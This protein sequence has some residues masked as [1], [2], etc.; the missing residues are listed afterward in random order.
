MPRDALRFDGEVFS[1]E[2][3]PLGEA[4]FWGSA[5]RDGDAAPWRGWIRLADLNRAELP[6]GRYRVRAFEGWEGE[7]EPVTPRPDRVFEIELLPIRGVG[8]APWPDAAERPPRNRPVWNDTPPRT[9]DDRTRFPP[10]L[11]PL[12]TTPEEGLLP[13]GLDWSPVPE[14]EG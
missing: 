7:F 3:A 8:D 6:A 1:A 11:R 14:G 9:A 4:R 2:G 12:G 13:G 5:E 10:D